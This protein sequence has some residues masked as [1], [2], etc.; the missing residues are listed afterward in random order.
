MPYQKVECPPFSSNAGAAPT[1]IICDK[2]S[3]FWCTGFKRWCRLRGIHP[4]FGA[5]GK[6][7]SIAVVERFIKTLKVEGT[8]RLLVPLRRE[9]FRSEL[10]LFAAWYNGHRPHTWLDS[11]TPDEV[12]HGLPAANEQPRVEP[13]ARWPVDSACAQPRAP[14]DGKPG[15]IVELDVSHVAGRKHLPIV[16]LRRVA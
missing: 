12:Y 9:S 5:V 7:G 16:T 3:Q 13:R 1:Y 11:R 2:G 14:V 6:Q 15:A 10:S 8:R 4:R